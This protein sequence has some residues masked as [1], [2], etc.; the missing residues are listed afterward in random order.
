[1][2]FLFLLPKCSSWWDGLIPKTEFLLDQNWWSSNF[3]RLPDWP[4]TI[5]GMLDGLIIHLKRECL[6][7]IYDFEFMSL[8]LWE[9]IL[10]KQTPPT[11]SWHHLSCSVTGLITVAWSCLLICP[12]CLALGFCSVQS[13]HHG[14]LPRAGH[15][16]CCTHSMASILY[17][18]SLRSQP[19]WYSLCYRFACVQPSIL[20]SYDSRW[21]VTYF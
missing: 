2:D 18:L 15:C 12:L 21:W 8:S 6:P 17:L 3:G 11:F 10:S 13:F 20:W 14:V 7:N 9:L 19:L 16:L 4:H 1:M 5:Y